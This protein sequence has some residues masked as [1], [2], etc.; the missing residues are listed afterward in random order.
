VAEVGVQGL[1]ALAG[2][3]SAAVEGRES[4]LGAEDVPHRGEDAGMAEADLEH[5]ILVDQVGQPV[6]A[7]FLVHLE[8]GP[9]AL[10]G[11]EF[12]RSCVEGVHLLGGEN[13]FQGEESVAVEPVRL[14]WGEFAAGHAEV[15]QRGR[16]VHRVLPV[17]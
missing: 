16:H 14:G 6:G 7:L 5:G 15:A 2:E 9:V 17:R 8:A 10:G 11:G 12:G 3:G 4:E 13:V 1:V